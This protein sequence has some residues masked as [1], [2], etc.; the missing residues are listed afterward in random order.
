MMILQKKAMSKVTML[1]RVELF[2]ACFDCLGSSG[3][4]NASIQPSVDAASKA[5]LCGNGKDS[6]ETFCKGG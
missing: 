4:A 3:G 1:R 5:G 6:E 2:E